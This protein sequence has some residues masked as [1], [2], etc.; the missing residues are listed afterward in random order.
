MAFTSRVGLGSPQL[1]FRPQWAPSRRRESGDF[2]V[3]IVEAGESTPVEAVNRPASEGGSSESSPGKTGSY[4]DRDVGLPS[5]PISNGDLALPGMPD[6]S[7]MNEV[8]MANYDG[9]YCVDIVSPLQRPLWSRPG[10]RYLV[11]LFLWRR[12]HPVQAYPK[13]AYHQLGRR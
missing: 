8:S 6:T 1:D 3:A 7:L 9:C 10:G 13:G 5:P 11:V 2:D 12:P 4:L